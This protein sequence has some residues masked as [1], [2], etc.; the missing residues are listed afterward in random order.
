MTAF[1]AKNGFEE[2]MCGNMHLRVVNG[3]FRSEDRII[4]TPPIPAE[5]I[6][7]YLVSMIFRKG[8][9]AYEVV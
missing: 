7:D 3:G 6:G 1:F 5:G 9:I 8:A 2:K 4:N